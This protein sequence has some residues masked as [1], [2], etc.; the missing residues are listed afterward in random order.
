[1][2]GL[3]V[4]DTAVPLSDFFFPAFPN[5]LLFC[6]ESDDILIRGFVLTS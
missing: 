5:K 2:V 4:V 6:A 3:D 1:M